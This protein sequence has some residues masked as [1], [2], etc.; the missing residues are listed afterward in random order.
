MSQSLK[1]FVWEDTFFDGVM[2]ALAGSPEEARSAV[3]AKAPWIKEE[4]LSREPVTY[5]QAIG[6]AVSGA[7]K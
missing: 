2:F 1:L 7:D 5:E 6:F 3:R 4:E